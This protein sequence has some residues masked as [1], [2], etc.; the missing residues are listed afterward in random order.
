MKRHRL[1]EWMWKLNSSFYCIQETLL[2]NK[3]RHYLRIYGWKKVFQANRPQKQAILI[4]NKT[5]FQPKLIKRDGE[6]HFILFKGKIHQEDV[7][8]LNISA[9]NARASTFIKETLLKLKSHIELH[10][11]RVGGFNALL[12]PRQKLNRGIM[13]LQTLWLK[14]IW[15]IPTERFTQSQKN[16]PSSQHFTEPSPR[17]ATLGQEASLNRYNM[18]FIRLP[19]IKAGFNNNRNNTKPTD[20]R[21]LNNSME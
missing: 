9:L 21:K 14:W 16:I 4:T 6:G 20:L 7:S 13:E 5:D 19:W 10:M 11:L 8:V 3:D 12:L 15:Q 18:Y 17:L 2:S 1:T